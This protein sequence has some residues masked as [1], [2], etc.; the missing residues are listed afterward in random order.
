MLKKHLLPFIVFITGACVLIIEIVAMRLLSPYFGNTIFTVSSVISVILAALSIGYYMGGKWADRNPSWQLFFQIILYSGLILLFIYY[1]GILA[2]PFLSA[3][4]SIVYGPL[5][6]ALFLFFLPAFLLGTLSP[7][8]VKLQS[9]QLTEEGIGTIAGSIFFWSTLGSILGSLLAGFYLIP[10]FGIDKI[11]IGVGIVLFALG[12]LPLLMIKKKNSRM[13]FDFLAFAVMMILIPLAIQVTSGKVLL[14]KDGLYEKIT[15]YDGNYEGRSTRFFQQDRSSSGAMF[16][17]TQDPKDLVYEYT[18]YYAL[19]KIFT[20]SV[21]QALVIGGG[22]YSIPKALLTSLPNATV[23]VV[24][25]EPLLHQLAQQ[26]F[27]LKEDPRLKV[28][29][30]DGRRFLQSSNKK[31]DLIFS[32]V[33]YSLFSIPSHFTTQEFFTLAKN[34]LNPNGIF[35]ANLIGDLKPERTSFILSELKTFQ[36]IFPNSY[37]FAVRSPLE[38]GPQNLIFVGYNSDQRVDFSADFIKNNPDPLIRN[39]SQKRFDPASLDLSSYPLL[40]DNYSPVEYL[41][42]KFLLRQFSR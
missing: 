11:F 5:V 24:E 15:I 8:A 17:D 35:I 10:N 22:A 38:I 19:Y 13:V 21:Q 41:T 18:K 12:F 34:K 36:S 39:L 42:G 3:A 37:F 26:Y 9:L 32:D 30:E 33:Y 6:S 27:F 7:Y 16:L 14:K 4:F 2:L 1:L 29:I 40:T 23:D 28:H 20:P 25:I 31:Y